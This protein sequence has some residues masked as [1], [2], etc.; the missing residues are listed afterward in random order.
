M[1][2]NP[3]S[4]IKEEDRNKSYEQFTRKK[5]TKF[6]WNRYKLKDEK[7]DNKM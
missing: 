5:I 6:G 7:A 4:K 3:E 2:L 1:I